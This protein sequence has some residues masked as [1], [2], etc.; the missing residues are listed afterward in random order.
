MGA[1]GSS[2]TGTSGTSSG[3]RVAR[4]DRN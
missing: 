3:G 2:D 1:S 4:T